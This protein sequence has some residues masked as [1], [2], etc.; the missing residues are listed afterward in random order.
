MEVSSLRNAA[1]GK[2]KLVSVV[3]AVALLLLAFLPLAAAAPAANQAAAAE[4][5]PMIFVHGY[6]G[7]GA[8]FESQ[9]MRFTTNGYPADYID[10]FEYDSMKYSSSGAWAEVYA[11]L[12]L[13]IDAVLARTGADKVYVLAHSLGTTVMHAYLSTPARAARVAKYVNIDGRTA[14]APPGGVPTLAIWAGIGTPGRQ[15]V[16]ATNVTVPNQTHVESATSPESFVAMYRFLTGVEPAT[17]EI[18]PEPGGRVVLSGRAVNF[19]QNQGV[20]GGTMQIWEVDGE[21]GR[22]IS[23]Q[24]EAVYELSGEGNWG[25]FAAKAGAFY[26]FTILRAGMTNHHLYFE[27]FPRS[28]HLVRVNTSPPGGVADM[29]TAS[30]GQSDAVIVRYKE[31]WGDQGENNDILEIDGTNVVN[32]INCPIGKRV[33]SLFAYDLGMDGRSD[34]STPIST[35]LT[36]PFLCGIDFF[37]RGANPPD[38]TISFVLTPR[39]GGGRKQVLNVPNWSS[40]TDRIS[41]QF[42]DYLQDTTSFYFAEGYTGQGLF[43]EYLCLMNPYPGSTTAH[44]TYMFKDGSTQT[45]DIPLAGTSRQTVDVNAAVGPNR[46]VAVK[47]EA[48]S[49]IVAERPMYFNFQGAW[50]G[51]HTEVGY[52]P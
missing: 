26:E 23:S 20:Q 2:G 35:F 46:E 3:A 38:D 30:P 17:S 1:R 6:M 34:L 43:Q 8:Q 49:P 31:F 37:I 15:I 47:I 32:H 28:D 29:M 16:G 18:L 50:D 27:P 36:M 45:Q 22:R 9:A 40:T 24:P 12:D 44:L 4:I 21:N 48:D 5:K 14:S 41:V 39:G 33:I 13:K 52:S 25:P 10:V 19:P 11:A 7:S 42:N 51:G